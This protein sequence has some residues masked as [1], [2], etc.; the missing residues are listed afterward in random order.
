MRK[1]KFQRITAF[2]VALVLLLCGSVSVGAADTNSSVTDTSISDIRDLLNAIS[3]DSYLEDNAD[4]DRATEEVVIDATKNYEFKLSKDAEAVYTQDTVLGDDVD[5]NIV[6]H[7][8]EY[9]GISGLYVPGNGIVSWKTDAVK[10]AAKYSVVIDYYPV[11]NK[12]AS[13]ERV[14]MVNG[15]VPFAEARY[16]TISKVWHNVYSDGEFM[17]GEGESAAEYL[18]KADELGIE[19]YSED[20]G[21]DGTYI[22]YKMPDVWTKDISA[23]IDDYAVRFFTE[24]IDKNEIR[25]SLTQA[26]VWTS[27]EF[28]DANGFY[29]ESFEF[30]IAPDENGIVTLSLESVNEPI[31]ISSVRLVPHKGN[32][33]YEEYMEIY[34]DEPEGTD[35]IKIEAEYFSATSSQT[36]YPLEDRTSAI[37]SPA[38]TDRTVLN[39]IGGEKWQTAG[40]WVEYKFTVDNSGLYQIAARY[41]QA[42]LDGMFVSRSL[43]IYS[44]STVKEGDKGYYNGVP[45]AEAGNLRFGYSSDWQSDALNDGELDGFKFY[46]KEDVVYTLR[47]EVTLGSMGQIVNTV[48]NS[49][50]S[51]NT[52]YLN[53]L[54]LTGS[55]PD[56]N[57]DY[58]FNR[59]MPDTMIDFIVQARTLYSVAEDLAE[60]AGDKSSM[61]ATLEKI[62]RLLE[63]MGTDEDEVAKNLEQLK[64]N[65][66]SLGT[67]LGDAKTQPLQLDLISVQGESAELPVAEAGFWKAIVYEFTRFF[68]SFFRN[69]D[70][71]GAMEEIKEGESV[72]VWLA[73]GRDQSQVIRSLVNNDFTPETGVAIDLKLVSGGTLLPSILSGMGPDVYIGLG[74]SD[75]INYAIRG[76]LVPVEDQEDFDEAIGDF[77]EAAMIVLGIEDSTGE[78]HYYGIPETQN[79]NMMFVREDVLAELD[80]EVPKTW[81]DVLEA[82]PILQANNMQIGMHTD[83]KVFLYQM[84]GELYADDG[85]R[86]NLDSNVALEAFN[87]MCN[88]FTM[89]SFP[90]KYDFANRFRTGEMPIGFAVY[91]GTYNQLKVFATEI[92]GLWGFYPMPGYEDEQGNINNVSVSTVTAIVMITGCEDEEGAW[93]FMKWHAGAQCQVDYSNEM[94]ALIGPSAK[95]ATANMAALESMP[96]TTE[97][98]VQLSAQFNNLASIPNYPGSY[99]IDR[100]TNFAFL[101]AYNNAADP[102]TELQS[103]ITTINK[104][105]TRKRQE[106]DLETLDYVGQTLA[107]KRMLQAIGAIEEIQASSSYSNS[108]DAVCER[109]I[110]TMDGGSTEDYAS[111]RALAIALEEADADLFEDVIDYVKSAANAL[112]SYEAY[113]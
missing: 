101:A 80:I 84:D 109:A 18:S 53:I 92:E 30:V 37:T 79:F 105:I 45:F 27:Y 23:F 77:N 12:A 65:I 50:D 13:I 14:F 112:E 63:T 67:W 16:L 32:I 110:D 35:K 86:I 74:Q 66:G 19:A 48:Q 24:D 1:T 104:E 100:Y 44:D 43:H 28:R 4:V 81:D 82:I 6:A 56:A 72:E 60:I 8:E 46:F 83:Y 47:F 41:R 106:F 69:Y 33:T 29:Q 89:Y 42:L 51:I 57:R 95:H 11:K 5:K 3:Y 111:L 26:P 93:E 64:S 108:Y 36:I 102:V 40:Q 85:M 39:T 73:Y 59:V 68:K 52:D 10:T 49:L 78:F 87:T 107:E 88:M 90:Y 17:L 99:I 75:V 54:K 76:A 70:R 20:R 91:T 2:A 58:G 21:E 31:A 96:W 55:N 15:A 98:Y 38:A 25:A 94:V 9:D 7:V 22:I 34:G 103:Y 113:K 61:T 62:A 97:E 71:M